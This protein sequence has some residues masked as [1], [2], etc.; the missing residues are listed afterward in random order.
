VKNIGRSAA[1]VEYEIH[2]TFYLQRGILGNLLPAG[3]RQPGRQ[4][5]KSPL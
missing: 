2:A 4:S 1:V 5:M 3:Y